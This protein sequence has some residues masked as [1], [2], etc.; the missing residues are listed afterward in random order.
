[1]SKNNVTPDRPFFCRLRDV[2]SNYNRKSRTAESYMLENLVLIMKQMK[3]CTES[4]NALLVGLK[5]KRDALKSNSICYGCGEKGHTV[6]D[7]T[8]CFRMMK[9]S[10]DYSR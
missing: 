8:E 4:T 1:M 9:K 6:R 10:K 7:H 2:I 5:G 3:T